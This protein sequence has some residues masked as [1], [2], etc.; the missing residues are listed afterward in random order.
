MWLH[1]LRSQPQCLSFYLKML[2]VYSS[3]HHS[4][5]YVLYWWRLG[6]LFIVCPSVTTFSAT[7]CNGTIKEWYQKVQHYTGLLLN[8]VN[9]VK[10]LRSRLM[11]YK[12]TET[13]IQIGLSWILN[14]NCFLQNS[15]PTTLCVMAGWVELTDV[16]I[17]GGTC[18]GGGQVITTWSHSRP[19]W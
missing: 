10:V 11:A 1:F 17:S 16:C 15:L 19:A 14:Q 5:T 13:T 4:F 2:M 9:F 12:P 3:A 6:S 7:T 8:L 18:G